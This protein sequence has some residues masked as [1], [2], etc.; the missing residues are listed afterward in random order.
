MGTDLTVT[1]TGL[2]DEK[3][4][5]AAA[6]AIAEVERIE[7]LMSTWRRESPLSL[8]N[9]D[10]GENW[11]VTDYE[12]LKVLEVALH[13]ARLT[14]GAF[15]VTAGPL[16]RLWGFFGS[17]ERR[18]PTDEKIAEALKKTGFSNVE[19]DPD[20]VAVRFKVMGMEIDFGGIAKG[21]AVDRAV[22]E[23]KKQGADNSLVD[24][25]GN[26]RGIGSPAGREAW[27][28]AVRDPRDRTG[29]LGI[30][31]LNSAE[32]NWGVASSGQYERY[33]EY[34]GRRYGHIIDPR[35][36]RP[37]EGMLGATIVAPDAM[38][39]DALSTSVFVLGR[40]EG[41]RLIESQEGV[42]GILIIPRDSG[43]VTIRISH[44]IADKFQLLDS[45]KDAEIEV[46]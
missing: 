33:F 12:I 7:A 20:H 25:G 18:P 11:V 39:A 15:D 19:V 42:E 22:A 31:Q 38:T 9:R 24:L 21:Y 2:P 14:G 10:A 17:E 8:L 40:K 1:I 35:T 6:D 45:V 34:E 16:V 5:E 3:V 23:L 29:I 41:E 32:G 37:V 28:I 46:F 26:I 43:G 27:N 30:L 4:D 36:G 44:A 13:Y